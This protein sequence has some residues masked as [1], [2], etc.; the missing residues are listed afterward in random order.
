MPIHCSIPIEPIDQE[1]YHTID[2]FMLGQAFAVHNEFGRFAKEKLFQAELS[3]RCRERGMRVDR[4]VLI[5]VSFEGFSKDYYID[6]L[7]DQSTVVEAKCAEA[8]TPAHVGQ[9]LNY[10]LLTGTQHGSLVNF[11][12]ERVARRFVSTRLNAVARRGFE[13]SLASWP[14][15]PAFRRVEEAMVGLA[16]EV[17][18]GLDLALYREAIVALCGG[19]SEVQVP[20]HR[21]RQFLADHTMPM[22]LPEIGLAIT[23]LARSADTRHHLQRLL[24][25]TPLR[26][27]VWINLPLGHLHL[28][29]LRRHFKSP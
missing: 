24:D 11:R 10:L 2:R 1:A 17:G 18:L 7:L 15:E 8:I 3:S 25:H 27:L 22:I 16:G 5:R 6:L 26:G 29:Y 14:N 4:E 12:G 21:G 9:T 23:A 13:V 28:E 19:S 20:L